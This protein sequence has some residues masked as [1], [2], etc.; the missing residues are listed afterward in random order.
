MYVFQHRSQKAETPLWMGKLQTKKYYQ[1]KL[2]SKRL[3]LGSP[4]GNDLYYIFGIPF[5]NESTIIPW[6]GYR[7]N[8][9]YFRK[10]DQEVSNYTM[11]LI[12]N[13]VRWYL[14][15]LDYLN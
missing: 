12:A 13:F 9:K 2:N 15:I 5:F 7:V 8:E 14:F 1:I 4:H 3:T 10:E 11:H 6:Y